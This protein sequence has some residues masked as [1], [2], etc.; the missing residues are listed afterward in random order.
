M[1][2]PNIKCSVLYIR[3]IFIILHLEVVIYTDTARDMD[4]GPVDEPYNYGY[5]NSL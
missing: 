1:Q 5:L 3:S 4:T 2:R